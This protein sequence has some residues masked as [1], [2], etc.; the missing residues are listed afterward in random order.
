MQPIFGHALLITAILY[1]SFIGNTYPYAAGVSP[2]GIDIALTVQ[3]LRLVACRSEF[4]NTL[5]PGAEHRS[6]SSGA[7]VRSSGIGFLLS[8]RA[9]LLS[10]N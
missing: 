10:D 4:V 3:A 6:T 8:G 9:F 7:V 2:Q 5:S 1:L